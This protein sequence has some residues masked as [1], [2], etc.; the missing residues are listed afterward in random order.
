MGFGAMMS[1]YDYRC[2]FIIMYIN[3]YKPDKKLLK[4]KSE[5][6]KLPTW[7]K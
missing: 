5:S 3:V 1:N 6:S 2:A 4:K 7:E